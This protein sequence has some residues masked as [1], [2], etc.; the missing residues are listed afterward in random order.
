MHGELYE[1]GGF[2]RLPRFIRD[3]E[4]AIIAQQANRT[5][6]EK[7]ILY[8]PYMRLNDVWMSIIFC[9]FFLIVRMSLQKSILPKLFQRYS[10]SKLPKL[11]E[12]L[13][14]SVY[15]VLAFLLYVFIVRPNVA[16]SYNLVSNHSSVVLDLLTPFPPPMDKYERFYYSQACGFYIAGLIFTLFLDTRHSD[17]IEMVVHHLATIALIVMSYIY[18]Y[19]RVGIIT[20]ALHDVGDI[21]L[22][23]S[24]L[25]HHMGI[26]GV[27]IFLF[28]CFVI[29]FYVTRLVM[30]SRIVFTVSVETLQ[31]LI[32]QPTFNRWALFYDTYLSHYVY[33]VV[34]LWTLLLLHC[35]WYSLALRLVVNEVFYGIKVADEGDP[36]SDDEDDGEDEDEDE[37][38]G[39]AEDAE[40]NESIRSESSSDEIKVHQSWFDF[41][42]NGEK[43]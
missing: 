43:R 20:L 15:Y 34:F 16:Y 40:K 42:A 41:I 25:T 21:F 30:Y 6:S 26:K 5:I 13:F 33:F 12:N 8:S 36:R 31:V 14:Y 9:A 39:K 7:P 23:S 24:K 27:D 19:L 10:R 35:F 28:A 3:V 18:G 22:Y 37:D 11:Y 29:V 17:F 38:E 2:L 1:G 32:V 4:S